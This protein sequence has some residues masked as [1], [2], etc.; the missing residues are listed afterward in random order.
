MGDNMKKNVAMLGLAVTAALCMG[1]ALGCA[2]KEELR[3]SRR[4]QEPRRGVSVSDRSEGSTAAEGAPSAGAPHRINIH[5][6]TGTGEG[7]GAGAAGT[8]EMAGNV[9]IT[10]EMK[11]CK[12]GEANQCGL[13]P[14]GPS[15]LGCAK[16]GGGHIA[17][18]IQAA[19]SIMMPRKDECLAEFKTFKP[20]ADHKGSSDGSCKFNKA[21]CQPDGTCGLGV[22]TQ[23]EMQEMQKK[24]EEMKR[25]RQNGQ[26]GQQ[27]GGQAPGQAPGAGPSHQGQG[28][29]FPQGGQGQGQPQGGYGQ[30]Q[31]M[32]G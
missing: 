4:P 18:N 20:A 31:R 29:G 5:V 22:M 9:V 30:G 14:T 28:V 16:E 13:I 3:E 6:D 24:F 1:A 23:E 2:A 25:Q 19:Q 10:P 21:V 12:P 17:V 26:G 11:A 32:G 27:N 15:C 8:G 7:G